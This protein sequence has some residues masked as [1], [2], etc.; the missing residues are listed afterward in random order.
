MFAATD[1]DPKSARRE[2]DQLRNEY[3]PISLK[4]RTDLAK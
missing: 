2:L 3:L 1:L 4:L